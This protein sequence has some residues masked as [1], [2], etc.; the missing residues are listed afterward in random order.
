MITF[1]IVARSGEIQDDPSVQKSNSSILYFANPR[2]ALGM[3]SLNP[4]KCGD[5]PSS[6]K[7]N[8]V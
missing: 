5:E 1:Q 4:N 7:I 8:I 2:I 3:I 6:V